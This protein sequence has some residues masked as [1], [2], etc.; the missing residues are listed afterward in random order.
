[1]DSSHIIEALHHSVAHVEPLIAK[2]GYAALFVA[3]FSEG[4]GLPAP[5]QTLLIASALMAYHG[6]LHIS[7]VLLVSLAAS[8]L[9]NCA[10]YTLGRTAGK[11]WLKRLLPK[12]AHLKKIDRQLNRWGVLLFVASRYL[13]GLKQTLGIVSGALRMAPGRFL[14]ANGVACL[15]WAI[16]MALIPYW[17][18]RYGRRFLHY[19]R[20]YRLEAYIVACG[21][22]CVGLLVSFL[23]YRRRS[24]G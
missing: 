4:C 7:M 2:Y 22:I 5:G 12:E 6:D 1:M 16:P 21:L 8:F 18:D 9:G 14:L 19:S 24:S 17:I 20:E 23:L 15:C 10:G 3:I 13:E 11:G